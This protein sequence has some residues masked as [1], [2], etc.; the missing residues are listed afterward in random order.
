MVKKQKSI[1]I[2]QPY[3]IPYLG[4]F[5]LIN[6][7]DQFVVYDCVQFQRRGWLHRNK[8]TDH[9][10]NEKWLTLPLQ[11]AKRDTLIKDLRFT[12]NAGQEFEDRLRKF[13]IFCEDEKLKALVLRNIKIYSDNV[14]DYIEGVL[15]FFSEYL[16]ISFNSIRSSELEIPLNLAGEEK[17]LALCKRLDATH[18]LNAPGGK[19][20]YN[21]DRFSQHGIE[22]KFLPDYSGSK[23]SILTRVT[24]ESKKT[25]RRELMQDWK[26]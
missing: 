20:L 26:L 12:E 3:F 21:I 7:V 17:I 19:H 18:Y 6:H 16:D 2:M 10:G 9:S 25:I 22:I 4:Y 24:Q 14:V 5:R 13:P 23:S 1:A 15:S 11:K 8:L